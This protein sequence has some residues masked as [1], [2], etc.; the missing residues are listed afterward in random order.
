MERF[1]LR[2]ATL[3]D[4]EWVDTLG[5][6]CGLDAVGLVRELGHTHTVVWV[7][8]ERRG[9]L[10]GWVVAD[11]LQIQDLAVRLDARRQGLGRALLTHA[12][13]GARARGLRVAVLEFREDN[14]AAQALYGSLGFARLTRRPRYYADGEAALVFALELEDGREIS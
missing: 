11:E 6:D 14:H 5:Q 1:E 2:S 4:A 13:A 9:F 7:D 8:N 12:L 3:E 10:V